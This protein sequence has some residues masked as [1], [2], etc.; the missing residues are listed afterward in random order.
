MEEVRNVSADRESGV[1]RALIDVGGA[2]R[3]R[4][5][6]PPRRWQSDGVVSAGGRAA[7]LSITP[8]SP[9]KSHAWSL[10][11]A[12]AADHNTTKPASRALASAPQVQPT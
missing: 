6:P 12:A 9:R 8:A 7:V 4:E 3:E 11:P 5:L 2:H 1:H 10:P